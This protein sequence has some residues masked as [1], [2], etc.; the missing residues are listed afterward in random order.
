MK[1]P[2][3]M[4]ARIVDD[5]VKTA[6][7]QLTRVHVQ[8]PAFTQ[9]LDAIERCR[10]LTKLTGRPNCIAIL[11]ESGVGKSH[12]AER[13][14]LA[15]P[16]RTLSDRRTVPVL[17]VEVPK[18]ATIKSLLA[19]MLVAL[20][21]QE[22]V[23]GNRTTL[24]RALLRL[25]DELSV[26]TIVLDEGQHMLQCAATDGDVG[27][28]LKT[29]INRSH[30]TIVLMGMP[31]MA[32]L[33]ATSEYQQTAM[34]FQRVRTIEPFHWKRTDD[35][36]PFRMFLKQVDGV[37]PFPQSSR[38]ADPE[39]ALRLFAATRGYLR[40]VFRILEAACLDGLLS[41]AD[42]LDCD[43]LDAAMR[44]EVGERIPL[45]S[46][47]FTAPVEHVLEAVL[48]KWAPIDEP[49][50]SKRP[51]KQPRRLGLADVLVK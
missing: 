37:L 33:L 20:G 9:H 16:P 2:A 45:L 17:L 15:H 10:L 41:H 39:I 38:L 34:R 49:P 27:D 29:L 11:G 35:G 47:P 30:R 23:K 19:E 42:R 26:D 24:L 13:L 40:M 8:Y 36:K 5:R 51:G 1:T 32:R 6:L 22:S 31:S 28:W 4:T 46:A 12:L 14:K 3:S 7:A 21:Y 44:I 50:S 25:L 43:Y 48:G 18:H